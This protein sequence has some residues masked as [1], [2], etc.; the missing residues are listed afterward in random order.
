MMKNLATVFGVVML[1]IGLLGFV[2]GVTTDGMLLG[3]FYV[4]PLH[5]IIHLATGAVALWAGLT[6]APTSRLVFQVFGAVY[7]VIAILGF[8]TDGDHLFNLIAINA[9][10][11]WLHAVIAAASL[12]IGF[13]VKDEE[14]PTTALRT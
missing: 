4:N 13:G 9:A 3:V 2:P 12:A 8:L 5:N 7:G 6:S 11:N 10:G 1:A 14:A